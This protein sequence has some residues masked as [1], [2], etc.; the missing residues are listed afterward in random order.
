MTIN[1]QAKVEMIAAKRLHA[2]PASQ[3]AL[4]MTEDAGNFAAPGAPP[5][6]D[7]AVVTRALWRHFTNADKR[8]ILQ[9][10]NRCSQPAESGALMRREGVYSSSFST[11]RCQ[12]EAADL[13]A[14]APQN[15]GP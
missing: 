2:L 3:E 10:V 14:L 15:R 1:K 8:R 7:T 6:A 9:A 4:R 12:G 11:W 5:D 13:G